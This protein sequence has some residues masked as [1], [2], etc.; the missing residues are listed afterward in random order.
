MQHCMTHMH[1]S[2]LFASK[3]HYHTYVPRVGRRMLAVCN[4]HTHT[5]IRCR[6]A[7]H[8][9]TALPMSWPPQEIIL[10]HRWVLSSPHLFSTQTT[11]FSAFPIPFVLPKPRV[12]FAV[13]DRHGRHESVWRR[14]HAQEEN[15][16]FSCV[17]W[18]LP[19]SRGGLCD[20]AAVA[21]QR[22]KGWVMAAGGNFALVHALQQCWLFLSRT[23]PDWCALP[24][25]LG[26][27]FL[28]AHL[29]LV[30]AK[31]RCR[32]AELSAA[33][34]GRVESGMTPGFTSWFFWRPNAFV[35]HLSWSWCPL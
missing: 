5:A 1:R 10:G 7:A 2:Y 24:S 13:V 20:P 34:P 9:C 27:A 25:A 18:R 3:I 4:E 6:P 19:S 33:T 14:A 22:S 31:L 12:K 35:M 26:P 29:L 8:T 17:F 28:G 23:K 30:S 16:C 21:N 32:A 11:Y 15:P